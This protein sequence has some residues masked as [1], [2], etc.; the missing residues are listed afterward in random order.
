[1]LS[2]LNFFFVEAVRG[3]REHTRECSGAHC[4]HQEQAQA[5]SAYG[6]G[7]DKRA[8]AERST[9][10]PDELLAG[11][12]A[13]HALASWSAVEVSRERLEQSLRL[14]YPAEEFAGTELFKSI[15]IWQKANPPFVILKVNATGPFAHCPS[16]QCNPIYW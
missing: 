6:C 1:V 14:A 3:Q 10:L 16:N 2:S 9:D 12:R 15:T 8:D 7:Q 4:K 13:T 11:G 5:K